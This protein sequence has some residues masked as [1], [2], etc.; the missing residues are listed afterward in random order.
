MIPGGSIPPSG[1]RQTRR[2]K[3]GPKPM[4]VATPGRGR[5]GRRKRSHPPIPTADFSSQR[6]GPQARPAGTQK[7]KAGR[8]RVA[9]PA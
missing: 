7:P 8:A 4:G 2:G 1:E 6:A 9:E 3:A 5:N